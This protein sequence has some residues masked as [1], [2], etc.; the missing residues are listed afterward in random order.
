M[1]E[2]QGTQSSQNSSPTKFNDA[3]N[4]KHVRKKQ[5]PR[6]SCWSHFTKYVTEDGE[7]RFAPESETTF[8]TWKF[9]KD[10]IRKALIHMIIFRIVEGEGFKLFL[11]KACPRFHLPSRFTFRKDCLDLFNSMKNSFGQDTSR[12]CLTT[13]TWTSLQRVSYMVLTAHWIDEEWMLQKRIINFCPISAHRG[14][15]IGQA[16][17][18][19][20]R[21]WGIERI[22]TITV[23]IASANT[24]GVEY[25][26]KKLNHRNVAA[27]YERAFDSYARDDHSFF[28]DL[29]TGDGVPTFDDWENVRRIE[30]VLEPFYDLTL[31]VSG[32]LHGTYHFFLEVLIEI[33]CLLDVWASSED[34]DVISITSKMREKYNKYWG[35]AKKINFLV[36]FANIFDPRHKMEFEN[37]GV[38]LLFS[39][40]VADV[41]KTIDKELHCLF[42]EYSSISRRAMVYEG[43]SSIPTKVSNSAELNLSKTSLAMQQYLLKKQRDWLR[44]SKDPI[45]LDEYAA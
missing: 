11:S 29:L 17:E 2:S 24:V 34:L 15:N 16:L 38:K 28:L 41:M 22:F 25:L 9:D 10:A 35:D 18:K 23:D 42:D 39:D 21:D 19:C 40:I 4:D 30:K 44:K 43:Q 8:S 1:S 3:T 27:K 7:N 32:S 37:F 20:I 14:E 5:Q 45:N 12:I 13:D 6:A 36:Y 26:R 31:K 33:H